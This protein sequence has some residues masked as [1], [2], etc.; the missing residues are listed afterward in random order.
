MAKIVEKI[1]LDF[2]P[3]IINT[4]NIVGFSSSIWP[5]IKKHKIP[6][7]QV[8][9]DQYA[10]CPN[11]N[12]FKNGNRCATQCAQ[13]KIFRLPHKE[14]SN[15]VDAVIGVSNFVLQHHLKNGLFKKAKIKIG[16][17]YWY[18]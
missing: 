10:I 8:L 13:C 1:I 14:L 16:F 6:L 2:R 11:S 9:H 12:M 3:D 18:D 7:V 15:N 4:H 5:L 17:P